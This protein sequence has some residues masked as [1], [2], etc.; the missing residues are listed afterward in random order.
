MANPTVLVK[1]IVW[2]AGCGFE[3]VYRKFVVVD[4]EGLTEEQET[5][6]P[7]DEGYAVEVSVTI[8]LPLPQAVPT[9]TVSEVGGAQASGSHWFP[10]GCSEQFGGRDLWSLSVGW[11]GRQRGNLLVTV[12]DPMANLHTEWNQAT[13]TVKKW[14]RHHSFYNALT[15]EGMLYRIRCSEVTGYQP[16]NEPNAVGMEP[17]RRPAPVQQR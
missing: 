5:L 9:R 8:D 4:D 10:S 6:Q 13:T 11:R 2:C 12:E 1:G 3:V 7:R 15:E 17:H 16:S 14:I